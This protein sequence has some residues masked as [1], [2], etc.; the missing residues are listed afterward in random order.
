MTMLGVV[1]A[2][3]AW[4]FPFQPIRPSPFDKTPEEPK[5]SSPA[6]PS[7]LFPDGKAGYY[8]IGYTTDNQEVA[9]HE[10]ERQNQN[11][12]HTHVAYSSNWSGFT[13]GLYIVIYGIYDSKESAV[14]ALTQVETQGIN[15]CVKHSGNRVH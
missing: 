6:K 12:F 10:S 13:P 14:A 4:L 15:A 11:G 2:L 9:A 8:L 5:R 1:V 3:C 7:G